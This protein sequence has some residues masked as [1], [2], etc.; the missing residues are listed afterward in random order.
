[1]FHMAAISSCVR[2][3]HGRIAAPM[4]STNSRPCPLR[5]GGH[6]PDAGDGWRTRRVRQAVQVEHHQPRRLL[7]QGAQSAAMPRL[8]HCVT[9]ACGCAAVCVL[10]CL[11]RRPAR[12]A[13][14][15]IIMA[16]ATGSDVQ[17]IC[18]TVA[19]CASCCAMRRR[20]Q[21]T[22]TGTRSGCRTTTST[23]ST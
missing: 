11:L 1:M 13:T 10:A 6:G 21:R 4:T 7:G 18:M 15:N 20:W 5:T 12:V 8:P 19:D 2:G 3:P 23:I 9:G 14:M 22:C 17:L 16:H